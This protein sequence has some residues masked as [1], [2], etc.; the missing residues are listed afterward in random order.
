M[1]KI[2]KV[3]GR[4]VFSII[5]E[6]NIIGYRVS[7]PWRICPWAMGINDENFYCQAY[8]CHSWRMG[9]IHEKN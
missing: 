7:V 6:C 1:K 8:Y 5:W 3:R 9:E 2:R 4:P